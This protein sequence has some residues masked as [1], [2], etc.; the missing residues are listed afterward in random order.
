MGLQNVYYYCIIL[1]IM[2]TG[3]G[4]V[5]VPPKINDKSAALLCSLPLQTAPTSQP[6]LNPG[7]KLSCRPGFQLSLILLQIVR[8]TRLQ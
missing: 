4:R 3:L 8:L 2:R 1:Q 5:T 6:P 7:T